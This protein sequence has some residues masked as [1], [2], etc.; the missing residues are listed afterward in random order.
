MP[1][2]APISGAIPAKTAGKAPQPG[3][4]GHAS[5][6]PRPGSAIGKAKPGASRAVNL[7]PTP[8]PATGKAALGRG[9]I[10]LNARLRAM[11]PH[12]PVNPQLKEYTPPVSLRGRLVPTPPPEVVAQTKYRLTE[13]GSGNENRIEMW[14][15][16][17]RHAGPLTLCSGWLLRFPHAARTASGG[18][19]PANGVQI[20]LFGGHSKPP[21]APFD[22]GLN[23]IVEAAATVECSERHLTPFS[24][25]SPSP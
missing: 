1:S 21:L 6:G 2:P 19:A 4:K 16:G 5:P 13:Y 23:P 3:P 22:E 17:I 25:A 20:G 11:L 10:D 15:T 24:P 18:G 8:A 14:V 12:N 9:P 7:P